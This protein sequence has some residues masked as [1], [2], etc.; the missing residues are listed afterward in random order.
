MRDS[1]ENPASKWKTK[2]DPLF[3][4]IANIYKENCDA[5]DALGPGQSHELYEEIDK[6]FRQR[7]AEIKQ[8]IDDKYKSEDVVSSVICLGAQ[9]E[10]EML[11]A[12]YCYVR[13]R[14]PLWKLAQE[15]W[16]GDLKATEQ[17]L[18]LRKDWAD[19]AKGDGI[20][21]LK[22]KLDHWNILEM[23]LPLGLDKLS[24]TALA[25]CFD[26]ICPCGEIHDADTLKKLRA[27]IKRERERLEAF[28]ET[29][30]QFGRNFL[31]HYP[32]HATQ[33]KRRRPSLRSRS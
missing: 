5:V 19:L 25:E 11:F 23:G 21:P 16:D 13:T 1:S 8:E 24:A 17:L 9:N 31:S 22:I 4:K 6:R 18:R 27:K 7:L 2:V 12:Y 29:D 33:S 32:L 3:L 28:K 10:E 30:S 14:K 26:E 15:E 20:K